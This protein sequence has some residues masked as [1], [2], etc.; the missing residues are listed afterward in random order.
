MRLRS[1]RSFQLSKT[2]ALQPF[3]FDN[4]PSENPVATEE[5]LLKIQVLKNVDFNGTTYRPVQPNLDYF[6]TEK[7]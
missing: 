5:N 2:T 3:D 4:F 6:S 7:V 1:G